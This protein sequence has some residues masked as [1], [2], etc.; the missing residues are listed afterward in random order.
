M[1]I[2]LT[3]AKE[4]AATANAQGLACLSDLPGGLYSVEAKFRGFLNVRYYPVRLSFPGVTHLAFRLPLGEIEEGG[5]AQESTVSGILEV[6]G[7][8]LAGASVC[9][10]ASNREAHCATTTDWGEYALSVVPGV[11]QI[12]VNTADAKLYRSEI[13]ASSPGIYRN[14]I[15][16]SENK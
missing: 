1:A 4:S 6:G 12:E 13:N 5:I 10:K 16:F 9:L 11:Y 7:K 3:T 2:G 14:R 15:R 8:V